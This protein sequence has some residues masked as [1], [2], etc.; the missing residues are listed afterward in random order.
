MFPL[1]KSPTP[2]CTGKPEKMGKDMIGYAISE[3]WCRETQGFNNFAE[4]YSPKWRQLGEIRHLGIDRDYG[5][6]QLGCHLELSGQEQDRDRNQPASGMGRRA[7][8]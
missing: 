4:C 1:D 3:Q 6:G 2:L 7:T 5:L 8:N